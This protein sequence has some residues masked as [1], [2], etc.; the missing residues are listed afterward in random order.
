MVWLVGML[1]AV[2]S[3]GFVDLDE[4]PGVIIPASKGAAFYEREDATALFTPSRAQVA[5]LEFRIDRFLKTAR[6]A[7]P[8]LYKRA[9]TYKR[10]YIGVVIGGKQKI[11]VNFFCRVMPDWRRTA[12]HVDDGGDCYFEVTFDLR[13]LEFSRFLT[14]GTT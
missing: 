1:L 2:A 13:T 3:D 12:Y 7:R 4:P 6:Y 5:R 10:Y 11:W 14:N 9:R 8:D